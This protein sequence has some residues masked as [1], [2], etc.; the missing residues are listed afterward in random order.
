MTFWARVMA[1]VTEVAGLEIYF[2]GRTS[3]LAE[4]LDVDGEETEESRRALRP[5]PTP[6][7]GWWH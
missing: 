1:V 5:L 7:G 4:G 6:Q 2:G 3:E